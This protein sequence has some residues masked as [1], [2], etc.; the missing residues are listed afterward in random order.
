MAVNPTT[1]IDPVVDRFVIWRAST[2]QFTNMNATWP[3][4][5]GGEIVGANPDFQYFKKVAGTPP[6]VD[7][8][9]TLTTEYGKVPITPAPAAG[10]PQGTYEAQYTLT[11]LSVADLKAQVDTEFQKQVRTQ[12]P[13]VEDPSRLLLAAGALARKQD[14][15]TLTADQEAIIDAVKVNEDSIK[16]IEARRQALYAAIDADADYDITD[17]WT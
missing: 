6:D 17:G 16:Q 4:T 5:D 11:K 15:A 1:G 12:F 10:L 3:R 14:G 8:R 9:F 13:A 2:A 7:H